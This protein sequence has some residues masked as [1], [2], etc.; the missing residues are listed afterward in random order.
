MYNL[1]IILV[2]C[3][4]NEFS[5]VLTLAMPDTETLKHVTFRCKVMTVSDAN[6]FESP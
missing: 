5:P 6:S 1:L 4:T 3:V 2:F